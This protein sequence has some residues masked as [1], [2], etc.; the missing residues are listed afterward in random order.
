ME[1][2]IGALIA[3]FICS[4]AFIFEDEC[5]WVNAMDWILRFP[6]FILWKVICVLLYPFFW[7]YRVF[8]RHTINPVS[9]EAIARAKILDDCVHLFGNYHLCIDK[10]AKMFC[11]KIFLF[12]VA[13]PP[14]VLSDIPSTPE[15]NF[16]IGVD[17]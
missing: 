10:K 11:N 5:L 8:L 14:V 17:N 4:I 16:R 12:R 9:P 2:I 7:F 13:S 3:W 6:C 15:G 1:Y